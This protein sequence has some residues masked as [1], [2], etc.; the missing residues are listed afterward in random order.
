MLATWALCAS[1]LAATEPP[2]PWLL[3]RRSPGT[4]LTL[5]LGVGFGSGF[6]YAGESRRGLVFSLVDTGLVAGLAGATVAL[7]QLVIEHDF[8]SGKSLARRERPFRRRE[9]AFYGMSWALAALEVASRTYQGFASF[10]AA[11]RTNRWLAGV[12]LAP[13]GDGAAAAL[14]V[15]L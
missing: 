7:N 5:G 11:R 9:K 12:A 4:A 8:T 6:Y 14:S 10:G 1:L 13:S 3:E 2:P 15:D